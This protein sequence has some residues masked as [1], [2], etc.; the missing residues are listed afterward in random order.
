MF[1]QQS[2]VHSVITVCILLCSIVYGLILRPY[3]WQ[4]SPLPLETVFLIAATITITYLLVIGITWQ[5]IQSAVV[6]KLSQAT[7]TLLLLFAIGILIGS[8]MIS[9][10]IPFLVYTGLKLISPE[11]FYLIAFIAP[12]FFSICTGTSWG[13]I[14]TIGLVLI[15]VASVIGA[16]LG[17]ATGAIVGGAYF[18][19]KLSPLSD[20]TNIAAIAVK[21][22]VYQHIKSMLVTTIPAALIAVLGYITLDFQSEH[23]HTINE[24]QQ[25]NMLTHT[26]SS[27][28]TLFTLTPILLLPVIVIIWGAI[29]KKPIL[30]T[31]ILSSIIACLLALLYQQVSISNVL[32]TIYQGFNISMLNLPSHTIE[33]TSEHLPS[34]FNRGGLYAL[35]TPIIII[36]LVFVYIGAIDCINAIPNIVNSVLNKL[37]S[38][39]SLITTTLCSSA[40]V[41]ALTSSQY[42][43]SFVVGEAFARKY[44]EIK[45]PR[46]VLSRSLEDTGTLIE[47]L[48]PWSTTTVFIF[49]SLNVS[50]YD[51]WQWQ[52]L[53]LANI[54]IA[55]IFAW[56]GIGYFSPQT[57]KE[58][59]HEA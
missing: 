30:P 25:V 4:Q 38:K 32:H 17:I 5:E 44:D 26:L 1:N 21:I 56:V 55:F 50:I 46:K 20:T 8:W 3:Q 45:L 15:T 19:D 37:K 18:G 9:G 23:A 54:A 13:S 24:E 27:I 47:S 2:I 36:I 48:V 53:S 52:F 29:A 49:A 28:E 35:N 59:T 31:L 16:D 43:N 33:S 34:L 39:A 10:T 51:Y 58:I 7:S 57:N 12:I 22:D 40:L 42:A 41:N 14:A 11:H 6:N